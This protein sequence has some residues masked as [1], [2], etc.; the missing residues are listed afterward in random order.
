MSRVLSH[1]MS[2]FVVVATATTVMGQDR[3]A[4][5][6]F[7]W[8]GEVTGSNVYVRSGPGSN[9]YPTLKLNTG[10]RVLV[11][12]DKFGWYEIAPPHGS[13][14]FVDAAMVTRTPG[15]TRGTTNQDRVYVRAGSSL[16]ER[17]RSATQVVLDKGAEVEITGETDGFFRVKP[18]KGAS[19]YISKSYVQPVEARLSSGLVD[20]FE[21]RAAQR[22]PATT[23]GENQPEKMVLDP[24]P[25]EEDV[26]PPTRKESNIANSAPPAEDMPIDVDAMSEALSDAA[27]AATATDPAPVKSKSKPLTGRYRALLAMLESELSALKTPPIDVEVARTL[28]ERYTEIAEQ[29]EERVP[30]E[31]AKIRMQ[32]IDDLINLQ[33]TRREISRSVAELDVFRQ[34][35]EA[36]RMRISRRR[37]EAALQKFDLEG[38][39]RQSYAFAPENRRYRLVDPDRGATIA[40]I[41]IP[42]SLDIRVQELIGRRV[43]V[44]TAGQRFSPSARTTIAVAASITEIGR[45]NQPYRIPNED[46]PSN[47]ANIGWNED[48][49]PLD[50]DRDAQA[51]PT[52][53]APVARAN[54]NPA[55]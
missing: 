33:A 38:E 37:T 17:R 5:R 9:W 43:G 46:D 45:A 23:P 53:E 29:D 48:N 25:S 18:P 6:E 13:F 20:R 35:L 8:E 50:I 12:G 49:P 7:P 21:Q 31:I 36:E 1:A 55:D 24:L 41:D 42:P 26:P 28:R 11:L 16:E 22:S 52:S 34:E 4:S 30:A 2:M 15:G 51:A 27:G 19:L 54:E 14:S 32:Q 44:H 47:P 39:L 3:P 40:Y 10:D